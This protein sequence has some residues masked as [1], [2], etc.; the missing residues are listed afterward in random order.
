MCFI[1]FEG[2]EGSGKTTQINSLALYL[3]KKGL[4]VT[5]TREPGGSYIAD[6]IRNILLD[7]KNMG[8]CANAELL[9][10][11]A[12]RAQHISDKVKKALKAGHIVLC[13]RFSDSTLAYQGFG[14][15]FDRR[16]IEKLNLFA[17]EGLNPDLTLLLD[18]GVKA[19]LERAHKSKNSKDRIE[20]ESLKFHNRVRKG[21]LKLAAEE[22]GRIKVINASGKLEE[23][24]KSI[25]GQVDK[26]LDRKK[27]NA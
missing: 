24:R 17:A 26:L 23:V 2:P 21:F 15:G 22:P 25:T 27:R 8:L 13:D 11:L 6:K 1:T 10:Y 9:L 14:R 18:I 12:S 7:T 16:L 20:K 19:G 4:K 5:L 3:R